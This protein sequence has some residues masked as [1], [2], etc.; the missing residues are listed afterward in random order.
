M[1]QPK[2][3]P[4][5]DID[6]VMNAL[7]LRRDALTRLLDDRRDVDKECHYPASEELTAEYFYQVF[8][9]NGVAA[10]VVDLYPSESWAVTPSVYEDENEDNETEFEAAWNELSA[11]LD[12]SNG[13]FKSEEGSPVWDCLYRL[14][15]LSGIGSYGVLLMGFDDGEELS[16]PVKKKKGLGLIYLRPFSHH[17]IQIARFNNDKTNPRYGLPEAYLITFLDPNEYAGETV[18]DIGQ[19]E[20]HWSRVVHV[21]DNSLSSPIYGV[22]RLRPVLNR[23]LDIK[24]VSGGSAEMFWKGAYPGISMETHPQLG[25]DVTIDATALK[26][27]V[28]SY[29]DGLQR[30]MLTK[31]MTAKPLS[32]QVADPT[33]HVKVYLEEICVTLRCP[34]RIFLGSE[35]GELASS[36]DSDTWDR[37]MMSR[38][39]KHITPKIIVPFVTR[40]ID[41]GVLP[42]PKEIRVDWPDLVKVSKEKQATIASTRMGA[43]SAYIQ[44]G[45]ES[46][47][48]PID[49]LTRE[50]GYDKDEATEIL[51]AKTKAVESAEA[52][53]SPKKL[54]ELVGGVTGMTELFKQFHE[55]IIN[56]KTL[57]GLMQLFYG[58]TPE[59]ANEII[60]DTEPATPEEL[61]AKSG[62]QPFGGEQQQKDGKF[63]GK[64]KT[65]NVPE[66]FKP[67]QPTKDQL[68]VMEGK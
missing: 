4:E 68:K 38:Q 13:L 46:M 42:T 6:M 54:L 57:A 31:G 5:T 56:K 20:V 66:Q 29:M 25:G 45:V 2:I 48:E 62:K 11:R 37:R 35:R 40:L 14:D 27:Q 33:G 67:K 52:A 32:P 9:R 28:Q 58:V 1:N 53:E 61:A 26:E 23:V 34:M 59:R 63:G 7:M 50:L 65:K 22:P 8:E 43:A 64:D 15:M 60:G 17:L 55:G 19:Q 49:F 24:K 10:R 30:M 3:T 44:G 12:G 47:M 39:Q 21:A 41:Y 36:Q 51:E 18:I 16:K